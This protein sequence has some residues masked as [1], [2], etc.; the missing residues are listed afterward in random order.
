MVRDA[1]KLAM[2]TQ[3]RKR[4]FT[5]SE[6]AK[7]CGVSKSTVSNWLAKKAFSKK[8]KKDNI[9]KA[10]RENVK[11]ITLV[12]KA[13]NAERKARYSE[14]VRSADTEFKHYKDNP[15]FV[16]GLML[17][18]ASGDKNDHSRIRLSSNDP[19]EHRIFLR[20]LLEFM[21]LEKKQV[22]F[23]LLLPAGHNNETQMKLWSKKTGL[24]VAQFGKTQFLASGSKNPLHNGTGN[25]II[26]S[27]VLKMKLNRWIER[28]LKE[29]Q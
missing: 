2:A 28:I 19:H 18:L 8:V 6:I 21:G 14:A 3:F 15:L 29:L 23:W 5:Y 11:R 4:G 20:F 7:I 13:R 17:Y 26:G 12:N 1:E 10:A 9:Q 16:A 22:K 24:S 25:T 27:T